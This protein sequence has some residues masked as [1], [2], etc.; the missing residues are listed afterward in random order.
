MDDL[1]KMTARARHHVTED[2]RI[3]D[4]SSGG[5]GV[6]YIP[7]KLVPSTSDLDVLDTVETSY[8]YAD[9]K[10]AMDAGKACI[11]KVEGIGGMLMYL[12]LVSEA[13]EAAF[14]NEAAGYMFAGSVAG[15][16]I[17]VGVTATGWVAEL[18]SP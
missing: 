13:P 6:L 2:G 5:G 12:P 1:S 15:G 14:G 8:T 18:P 17:G 11:L 4:G 10:A 9:V 3:A 7:V 16:S